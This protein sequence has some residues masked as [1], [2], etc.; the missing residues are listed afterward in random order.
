MSNS[1][2]PHR[3]QHARLAYPSPIIGAGSNS[4]LLSQW[5]RPNTSSSD[6]LFSSSLESFLS[7]G[8][9]PMSQFFPPDGQSIGYSAL[10]SVL[11]V[12]SQDWFPLG[13]AGWISS[14]SKGLSSLLQHYSSKASI[15][16]HSAFF[17][18]QLT[19][20][21]MTTGKNHSFDYMDLCW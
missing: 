12:I 14:Q 15:L 21:Y 17:I 7:S 20:P 11:P 9:F 3:L 8:S 18:V 16:K 5:Y 4:C 13:W 2:Q 6:G 10:A 19:H 1:L